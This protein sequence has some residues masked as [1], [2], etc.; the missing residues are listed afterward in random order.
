MATLNGR[1]RFAEQ[2]SP[3]PADYVECGASAVDCLDCGE[4]NKCQVR[5]EQ[6][7]DGNRLCFECADEYAALLAARG[8]I[9][10]VRKL[11]PFH[12]K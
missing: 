8:A 1:C 2:V 10:S 11:Q 9:A 3:D 5:L 7:S 4:P 12:A 6:A